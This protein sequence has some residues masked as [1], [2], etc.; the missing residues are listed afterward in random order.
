MRGVPAA[1][2]FFFGFAIKFA[3]GST[4]SFGSVRWGS[5]FA[6]GFATKFVFGSAG[7]FRSTGLGSPGGRSS[8]FCF[9]AASPKAVA[10]RCAAGAGWQ[11]TSGKISSREAWW[12]LAVSHANMLASNR[13]LKRGKCGDLGDKKKGGGV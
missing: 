10:S 8:F 11:N 5:W 1:S 12:A 7:L 13:K 9:G 4:G 2:G 6:F 3:F